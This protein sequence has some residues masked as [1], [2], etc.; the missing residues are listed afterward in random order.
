VALRLLWIL[1][2]LGLRFFA[3]QPAPFSPAVDAPPPPTEDR[4]ADTAG[5]DSDSSSDDPSDLDD[6]DDDDDDVMLPA[7]IVPLL[8][9]AVAA[10]Y[11][12]LIHSLADKNTLEPPCPPPRQA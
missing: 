1:M 2:V 4:I 12:W 3:P 9:I 8:P 10:R 6:D 5:S 7:R 11:S